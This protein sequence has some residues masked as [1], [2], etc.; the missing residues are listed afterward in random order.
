MTPTDPAQLSGLAGWVVDTIEALGP[1]GVGLLV[2]LETVF[3]PI[4]SEVVLP[5]A[6]LL[7]G[8]G[9]MS[10]ALAIA[11]A[12][13]GSLVG[14]LILYRAGAVLGS[15]RLTRLADRIPLLEGRD[16]ERAERWFDRHGGSAVLIGRFVPVVR[17]L[18]S[19]PAGVER[20][21]LPRFV[22]WTALGSALYNAVLVVAGYLLGS[23][24]TQ[25]GQYSDYL[26][27]AIYAA[28]AVTLGLFVRRR[29]RRGRRTPH[30]PT[31]S[32]ADG[33]PTGVG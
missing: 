20:M 21:P 4:P 30:E 19:I 3:P 26:N 31:P 5:V 12:T 11:G 2:A 15:D 25:I 18:V 9:R 10:L 6:G 7:A 24:W 27:Y 22:L 14:A 16:V 33:G 8:Q 23:R 13:A 29:L 1:A 17:S 32:D 28:L